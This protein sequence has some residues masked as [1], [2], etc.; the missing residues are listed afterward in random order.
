MVQ[1]RSTLRFFR[2]LLAVAAVLGLAGGAQGE[3]LARESQSFAGVAR[4]R[5]AGAGSPAA[6]AGE[7]FAKDACLTRAE[8]SLPE[9]GTE[10]R[11][12][13]VPCPETLTPEFWAS[14]QRALAVRGLH[15]GP[16]TG[17]PDRETAEAVRRYQAALGL[18]TPVLSLEAAQRLGL[19]PWPRERL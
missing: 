15:T 8:V 4:A 6:S 16:I 18:D 9:G 1:G 10:W 5:T 14:V 3:L 13:V 11:L 2:R 12:F 19:A 17:R 7:F